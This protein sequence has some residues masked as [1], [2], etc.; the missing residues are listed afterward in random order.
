MR[1]FRS[2]LGRKGKSSK[3]VLRGKRC[4]FSETTTYSSNSEHK[5]RGIRD[6]GELVGLKERY[7]GKGRGGEV[8][9]N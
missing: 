1:S 3:Q 9:L 4:R 2:R 5:F 7:G 8:S 6:P